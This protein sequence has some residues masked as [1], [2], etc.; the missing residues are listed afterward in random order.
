MLLRLLYGIAEHAL[1][2]L[3]GWGG[4]LLASLICKS[5]NLKQFET[6]IVGNSKWVA[7]CMGLWILKNPRF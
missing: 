3:D 2:F 4:G 1:Q 6:R 7:D 5:W